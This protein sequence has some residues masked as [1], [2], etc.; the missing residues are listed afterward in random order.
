M[1]RIKYGWKKFIEGL[2]CNM[3]EYECW[4]ITKSEHLCPVLFSFA[5]FILIMPRIKILSETDI[6]PDIHLNG[7]GCDH[8]TN[9]YGWYFDKIVCV[10]Y[11]YYRLKPYKR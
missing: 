5:G 1:P 10:D 9:N 8:S 11:P 2:C 4:S 6:I 3:S 7:E